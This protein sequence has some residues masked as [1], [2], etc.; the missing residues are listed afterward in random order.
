MEFCRRLSAMPDE[1]RVPRSYRLPTEAEWEYACRAG[2]TSKWCYGDD[3]SV[4]KDYAWYDGFFTHPVGQKKP[5]AWGLY[6]MHG[7]VWEWCMDRFGPYPKS[8]VTDPTGPATGTTRV[9]RGGSFNWCADYALSGMRHHAT[10]DRRSNGYGVRVVCCLAQSKG[11]TIAEKIPPQ[12]EPIPKEPEQAPKEQG[13]SD[14]AKLPVP[15]KSAQEK[16]RDLA[17]ELFGADHA[18]AKGSPE[19]LSALAARM[20]QKATETQDAAIQYTLLDIARII[21]VEAGD[22]T[23]AV[24]AVDRMGETFQIDSSALKAESIEAIVKSPHSPEQVSILLE[25]LDSVL[26]ACLAEDDFAMANTL[27]RAASTLARK[28]RDGSIVRQ[29]AARNREI[30]ERERMYQKEIVPALKSLKQH[31]DNPLANSIVGKYTCF[32]KGDWRNGLPKLAAGEDATIRELAAKE[33]AGLSESSEKL[34][35]ADGW[36]ELAQNDEKHKQQIQA[37]AADLYQQLPGLS[38]IDKMRADQRIK[39]S[40]SGETKATKNMDRRRKVKARIWPPPLPP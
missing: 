18:A 23:L 32:V 24:Q 28:S 1:R 5:N 27:G 37:H 15:D 38:G 30:E 3:E 39:L 19:K 16:A 21:S 13:E 14:T 34:K 4:L 29:V 7:N 9:W 20:A 31:P 35:V 26:E 33:V 12:P 25:S 36:W 40:I 8:P 22:I 10:T 6:D 11:E 17:K 2:S